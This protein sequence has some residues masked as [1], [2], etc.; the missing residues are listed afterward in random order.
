LTDVLYRLAD[1][2]VKGSD[3]LD[4]IEDTTPGDAATI[5]RFAFALRDNGFSPLTCTA[6]DIAW[7]GHVPGNALATINITTSN[8]TQSGGFTFPMEFHP[9]RDGWQLSRQTAD[10]VLA[11]GNARTDASRTESNPAPAAPPGAQ[12][13]PVGP[14]SDQST[15][16]AESP[17]PSPAPAPGPSR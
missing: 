14:S 2:A 4:L 6:T 11:F 3:K 8:P 1:P 10:M 9:F 17:P 16:P 7:S 12:P 13:A 15:A 5:D